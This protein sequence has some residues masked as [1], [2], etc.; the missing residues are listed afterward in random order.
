MNAWDI[1]VF[2]TSCINSWTSNFQH[3]PFMELPFGHA[4][5]VEEAEQAAQQQ[6]EVGHLWSNIGGIAEGFWMLLV[7]MLQI[8][9]LA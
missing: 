1:F 7:W 9:N 8:P 4:K 6:W 2:D 3:S 5:A